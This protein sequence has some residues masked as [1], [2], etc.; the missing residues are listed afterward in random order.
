MAAG[1]VVPVAGPY[2]ATWNSLPLGTQ[3]DDGFQLS[4]TIQGQEANQTDAYGMTLIF[5]GLRLFHH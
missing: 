4:C 2:T 5:S 1:L 3:N